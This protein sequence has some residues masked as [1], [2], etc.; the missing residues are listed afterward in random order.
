M[1]IALAVHDA[2]LLTSQSEDSMESGSCR[3]LKGDAAQ[4]YPGCV[5]VD[6]T[7]ELLQNL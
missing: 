3:V 2:K 1:T 4:S 6:K 7:V 5:W